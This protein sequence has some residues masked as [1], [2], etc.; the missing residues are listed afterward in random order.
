MNILLPPL[1]GEKQRSV[2]ASAAVVCHA[3]IPS[4]A[5]ETHSRHFIGCLKWKWDWSDV[6]ML[7][8]NLH[9]RFLWKPTSPVIYH[10]CCL[11]L[12]Y[13]PELWSSS[14]ITIRPVT[15]QTKAIFYFIF[16]FTKRLWVCT[17]L[18]LYD[19]WA[20]MGAKTESKQRGAGNKPANR[21]KEC[22]LITV[23]VFLFGSE[24]SMFGIRSVRTLFCKD[25]NVAAQGR[26]G[27]LLPVH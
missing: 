21:H 4:R 6:I 11:G 5:F 13:S 17:V 16:F 7:T 1:T 12:S 15:K 26:V 3:D 20:S 27:K 14:K 23:G 18:S 19:R 10:L 2:R 24:V 8:N 9:T 22:T 25:E